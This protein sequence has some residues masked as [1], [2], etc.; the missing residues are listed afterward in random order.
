MFNNF[1]QLWEILTP[2][3]KRKFL[4]VLIFT[5]IMACIETAGV[6]SIMPFLVV[7][8][9]PEIIDTNKTIHYLYTFWS[10]NDY[11][12]FVVKSGLISM[13]VV[14]FSAGFKI[15][16]QYALSR[17]SSLQRHYLATRLLAIYLKQNYEFFIQKNSAELAKNILSEV[18]Q[19][20]NSVVQPILQIISY[21]LVLFAMVI[22][23]FIYHPMMALI[24]A[25]SLGSMYI[26][27]FTLVKKLLNRIGLEFQAANKERYKSCQEVLGGI[28]DVKIN[29][30]GQSYLDQFNKHSRVYAR[31]LATS[32]TVSQVPLHFV[33]AVGYCSIIA[34]AMIL[35]IMSNSIET[36][37]PVLGLYGFAAYRMLPAA[38]NIYRAVAKMKFA[39]KAF[40][41][42]HSDLQLESHITRPLLRSDK[43]KFEHTIELR[44]V[45]YAYPSYPDKPIIDQF[46][47]IIPKNSSLG[48]IGRSGSGKSTLMDILLGLLH[49]QQGQLLIDG[50]EITAENAW[51]WQ[52][53]VGYVPQF[54]YLADSTVAENIAFGVEKDKVDM[55]AVVKAAQAAQIDDFIVNHLKEGYETTIGE[56]GIMLS[57]GQRQRIGLARALYKE[58]DVIFMDEATSALDIETEK[59]VNDAIKNLSGQKTIMIIAHREVSLKNCDHLIELTGNS[60][61]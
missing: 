51:E 17:F 47:L 59:A 35:V 58:P 49:P 16:N 13:G 8:A 14:L 28:K 60:K 38:Q 2:L 30:A 48:I 46:N 10:A 7:L 36:I 26:I 54:I 34:L 23:I 1:K 24:I 3:D 61:K 18:D 21:A 41:K 22:I 12:D 57:G 11:K 40:E 6:L 42:I 55:R 50:I 5:I 53:N 44:N 32:D 52:R 20:I 15:V 39:S 31:H 37:L 19:L 27:I 56:R 29:N 43:I 25:I 33:E 4:I 9:S 45:S